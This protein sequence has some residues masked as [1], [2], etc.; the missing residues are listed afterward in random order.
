VAKVFEAIGLDP[1]DPRVAVALTKRYENTDQVELAAY[2]LQREL[3]QSPN[4]T[5]AQAASLQGN[6]GSVGL[7][8]G[9]ADQQFARLEELYK[10]YTQNLPE[11]KVIE[12]NLRS[13][14]LMK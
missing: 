13:A 3:A 12:N 9:Q 11:I 10:N 4:P 14:G 2:R 7:S 5:D 6:A 8:A 1:K